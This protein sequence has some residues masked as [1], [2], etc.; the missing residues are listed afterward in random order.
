MLQ[1]V[2]S[3]N[4]TAHHAAVC[5]FKYVSYSAYINVKYRLHLFRWLNVLKCPFKS[6]S[7]FSSIQH[8]ISKSRLLPSISFTSF[9][10]FPTILS[11][12]SII[13]LQLLFCLP[14][15]HCPW[16]FKIK[17]SFS[18]AEELFCSVLEHACHISMGFILLTNKTVPMAPLTNKSHM[19]VR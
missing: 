9:P 7:S 4:H 8:T 11:S 5:H 1:Y 17:V 13:L 6:L 15:L 10:I 19:L 14:L 18:M 16:G 2:T 12:S 3:Y